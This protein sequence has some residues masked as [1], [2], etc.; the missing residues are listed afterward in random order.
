MG[1]GGKLKGR[2]W[3]VDN[4]IL[5][6]QGETSHFRRTCFSTLFT[7]I[8]TSRSLVHRPCCMMFDCGRSIVQE[9]ACLRMMNDAQTSFHIS[10]MNL[11][12]ML[13][14]KKNLWIS[15]LSAFIAVTLPTYRNH[16]L[17]PH[18]APWASLALLWSYS[19]IISYNSLAIS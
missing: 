1:T 5:G 7:Y 6:P 9:S 12:L 19:Y 16:G 4:G 10:W 14:Q 15:V 18:P 13:S 17:S 11:F 2:A 8:L 3:P